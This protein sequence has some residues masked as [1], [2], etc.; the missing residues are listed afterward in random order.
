MSNGAQIPESDNTESGQTTT[1]P[2]ELIDL[3]SGN[4]ITVR[5]PMSADTKGAIFLDRRDLI[6]EIKEEVKREVLQEIKGKREWM[7]EVKQ[8]VMP[9]Y[10]LNRE[11]KLDVIIEKEDDIY[12]AL[13][14][15]IDIASQG[16]SIIDAC[17][18]LK[19]AFEL[20]FDGESETFIRNKM[21]NIGE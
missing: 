2:M 4:L 1:I 15:S 3:S 17:E 10:L 9:F 16:D 18:N 19:D 14:P 13:I 21:N 12:V 8:L 5:I 6:D 7:P 20:Y 11:Y